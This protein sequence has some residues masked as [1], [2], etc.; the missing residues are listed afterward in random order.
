MRKGNG[1]ETTGND[2]LVPLS[3]LMGWLDEEQKAID[4][5]VPYRDEDTGETETETVLAMRKTL[6]TEELRAIRNL[7][8]E[9]ADEMAKRKE[10]KN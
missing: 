1:R 5:D 8:R 4:D 7:I 10:R 2:P 6:Y 9:K 3:E